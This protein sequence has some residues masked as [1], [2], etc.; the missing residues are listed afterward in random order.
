MV[1]IGTYTFLKSVGNGGEVQS[2]SGFDMVF[3]ADAGGSTILEFERVSWDP[4]TGAV[5]LWV[6]VP[7]LSSSVDTV[8][9]L[10]S[11]NA[12][13][14]TDQSNPTALW[15][16]YE[17]V[18][19][20]P[21]GTTLSLA[22]STTVNNAANSFGTAGMG[23]VDGAGNWNTS[24]YANAP[25]DASINNL[26]SGN[27]T[28]EFWYNSAN[29]INLFPTLMS[30]GDWGTSATQGW[31]IW[32]TRPP[33][34]VLRLELLY[35]YPDTTRWGVDVSPSTWYHVVI[36]YDGG[37]LN[38]SAK[39]YLNGVL[40]AISEFNAGSGSLGAD[41]ADDLLI[42]GDPSYPLSSINGVIDEIRISRTVQSVDYAVT[43]FNN[44]S[45]PST[46]YSIEGVLPSATLTLVKNVSGGTAAPG[47]FT[48][49]A[50]GSTPVSGA[51]GAGPSTVDPGTYSLSEEGP[52]DYQQEIVCVGG[53]QVGASIALAD[54]ES[55]VC[56]F[57]N[58]YVPPPDFVEI[59]CEITIRGGY[60]IMGGGGVAQ[61]AFV[62]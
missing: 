19:H 10:L 37:V 41:A 45:S 21:D 48:V 53:T 20:L 56:T 22:D 23:K 59:S 28:F 3:A 55:A 35:A 16:A 6:K 52:P 38:T 49:S 9:Y 18:Y 60:V 27:V 40:A 31:V 24:A 50:A 25:Q 8:I 2:A 61:G 36:T 29:S 11:G 42:G 13:V 17:A 34:S 15:A 7:T 12:A 43:N 5:E 57:T 51:G 4:T 47:D 46:F 32:P 62:G 1:I 14:I 26:P 33:A 58:T 39:I 44:Q 54:G 30:K